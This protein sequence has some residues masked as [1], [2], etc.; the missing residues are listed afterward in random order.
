MGVPLKGL[1]QHPPLVSGLSKAISQ[2]V[3]MCDFNIFYGQSRN[4]SLQCLV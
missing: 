2:E 1:H 4:V 3:V